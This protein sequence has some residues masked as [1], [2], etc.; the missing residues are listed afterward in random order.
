[1][2][3]LVFHGLHWDSVLQASGTHG[4]VLKRAVIVDLCLG[5]VFPEVVWGH[6]PHKKEE[7]E[8]P[9][10]A[11]QVFQVRQGARDSTDT[12]V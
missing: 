8:R 10:A 9:W 12:A 5:P 7:L 1:M 3:S 11:V 2:K 4:S 6:P